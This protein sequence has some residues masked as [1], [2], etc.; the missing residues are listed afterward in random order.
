MV[1]DEQKENLRRLCEAVKARRRDC[2]ELSEEQMACD[3][4]L[5]YAEEETRG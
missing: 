2:T 1:T 4:F 5:E 3:E